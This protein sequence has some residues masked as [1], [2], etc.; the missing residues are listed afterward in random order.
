KYGANLIITSRPILSIKKE[1]K[2]SSKLEIRT[3]E[4]DVRRYLD[5]YIFRLLGFIVRNL[6]L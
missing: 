3:R 2:G 6:E 1:F 5:S 4:E